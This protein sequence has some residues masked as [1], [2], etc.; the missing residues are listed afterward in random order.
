[1]RLI[2]QFLVPDAADDIPKR[3]DVWI[4]IGDIRVLEIQPVCDTAREALPLSFEFPYGLTAL[5]IVGGNAVC[6]DVFLALESQLFLN[7]NLNGKAMRIP[8]AF[9]EHKISAHC[10][11]AADDVFEDPSNNMVDAGVAVCRRWTFKEHERR[12]PLALFHAFLE[13]IIVF[14]ESEYALFELL[15]IGHNLSI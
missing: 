7:L 3:L 1:M 13:D 9:A 5:R 14:P 15:E 10:L 6:L 11:I 12:V 8:P 2:Q 4:L